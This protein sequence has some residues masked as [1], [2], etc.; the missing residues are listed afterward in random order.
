MAT[1]GQDL[2]Q[3]MEEGKAHVLGQD[4]P[5]TGG[6]APIGDPAVAG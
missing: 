2:E 1:S 4:S 3:G 5:H 6:G